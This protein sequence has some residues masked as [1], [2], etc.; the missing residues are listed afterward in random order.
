[1]GIKDMIGGIKDKAAQKAFD[2]E[3]VQKSWRVHMNAFGPILESAFV[4]DDA[5][6]VE[7][8]AALND[9]SRK[10]IS[11]GVKKLERLKEKCRNDSDNACWHF[12][13]GLA[14][15]VGGDIG[16]A[17]KMYMVAGQYGHKF[18]LPYLKAAK[19]LYEIGEY[20]DADDYFMA[21]ESCLT[22]KDGAILS[23]VYGNHASC[24]TMMHRFDVALNLIDM[25]QKHSLDRGKLYATEAIIHAAEHNAAAAGEC[26]EKTGNPMVRKAVEKVVADILAGKNP[27]FTPVPVADEAVAGFWDYFSANS[28]R[29][30]AMIG[31]EEDAV[32]A[33]I[34]SEIHKAMPFAENAPEVFLNFEDGRWDV[35]FTDHYSNSLRC[36]F[37]KLI[38]ARPEELDKSW[39]FGYAR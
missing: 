25:A 6:R 24:L 19:Y 16:R 7:L 10:D 32:A 39:R 9:I 28:E 5:S 1:M 20:D 26:L 13:L 21:A 2:S 15:E 4:Y 33:E 22:E 35:I 23:A 29:F 18:Y 17:A 27:H 30:L 3:A 11:G 8:T 38:D 34:G 14:C 12:C 31:K 36:G 37:E